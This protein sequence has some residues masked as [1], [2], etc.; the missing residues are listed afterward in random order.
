MAVN[1][2]KH[3]YSTIEVGQII[4]KN[5]ATVRRM[6]QKGV[7]KGTISKTDPNDKRVTVRIPREALVEYL[8]ENRLLFEDTLLESF[9]IKTEEKT[10]NEIDKLMS[11]PGTSVT[12]KPGSDLDAIE[13]CGTYLI[14]DDD[15][16]GVA[17]TVKTSMPTYELLVNGRICVANVQKGTVIDIL[18]TLSS[19]PVFQ[20][21]EITVRKGK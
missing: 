1:T 6:V 21:T 4:G 17:P 14:D 9:G 18:R 10:Q 7:I 13:P 19:D 20:F 8:R 2:K 16:C 12:I 15:C 3:G 11:T 5:Y